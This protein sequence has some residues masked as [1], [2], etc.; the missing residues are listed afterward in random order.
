MLTS[1]RRRLAAVALVLLVPV[2][3][4]C[5]FGYQTD[6]VYQPATGV[7]NRSGTVDVLNAVVVS[8][9]NGEGTFVASLVNKSDDKDD[10]LV[11]MSGDGLTIQLTA[12]VKVPAGS[13]V[14]LADTGAVSV[15]GDTVQAGKF[16]RLTLTFESGQSTEINAPVVPYSGDFNDVRLATPKTSS[17]S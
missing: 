12:P 5:G 6:Q 2:L 1:T 7:N 9:V 16:V 8:S 10:S 11:S 15:T 3:G 14:N 13:L 17:S 4:A